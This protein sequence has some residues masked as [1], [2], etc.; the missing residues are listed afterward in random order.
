MSSIISA[1]QR[2][3]ERQHEQYTHDSPTL[4]TSAT[5]R[6]RTPRGSYW[7]LC[8]LLI[9]LGIAVGLLHMELQAVRVALSATDEVQRT[10]VARLEKLI[11]LA[12]NEQS[13]LYQVQQ[14]LATHTAKPTPPKPSVLAPTTIRNPSER[15]KNT[16]SSTSSAAIGDAL[17]WAQAPEELQ[18]LVNPSKITGNLFDENNKERSFI[19]LN[20]TVLQVGSQLAEMTQVVAI[21]RNTVYLDYKGQ[22]YFF[23]LTVR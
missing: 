4:N 1:L 6:E 9:G 11:E 13:M 12:L 20:D 21:E 3:Q 22:Q 15:A 19:I 5:P 16:A 10:T 23:I 18:K 7:L 8:A 14:Q 17:P 2:A